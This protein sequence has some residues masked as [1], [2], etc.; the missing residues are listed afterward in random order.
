MGLSIHVEPRRYG[1]QDH[2][3]GAWSEEAWRAKEERD[4]LAEIEAEE[5]RKSV[6][7]LSPIEQMGVAISGL[8][9]PRMDYS[10]IARQ[11]FKV[12]PLPNP[13]RKVRPKGKRLA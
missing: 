12:E 13:V 11:I 7:H 2:P 10:G 8:L 3:R 5:F 9:R 1:I 4:R 6:A